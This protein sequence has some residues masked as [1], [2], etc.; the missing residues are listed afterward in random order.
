MMTAEMRRQFLIF[1]SVLAL[2]VAS[3][4]TVKAWAETPPPQPTAPFVKGSLEEITRERAGKP[5]L[6]VFWSMYCAP[7]VEEMDTWKAL[8][9]TRPDF[10]LVMVSTDPIEKADKLAYVLDLKGLTGVENWAFAD[11]MTARVRFSVDPQWRG[12]L[13][14]IHFVDAQGRH[15]PVIGKVGEQRVI[16]WLDAQP[17]N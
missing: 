3:V 14:R 1:S 2:S 16:D 5:F 15:T 9:E 6:L 7:C 8:R 12:E 4:L 13:P 11:A 17:G 10:D